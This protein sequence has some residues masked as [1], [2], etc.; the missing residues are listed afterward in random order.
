MYAL[1]VDLPLASPSPALPL[2]LASPSPS[3]GDVDLYLAAS[4]DAR[5][6]MEVRHTWPL[7]HHPSPSPWPLPHLG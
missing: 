6:R 5:P 4:W 7:S 3:T 2:P 1:Y